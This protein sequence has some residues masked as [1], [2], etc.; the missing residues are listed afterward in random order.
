MFIAA[1]PREEA[2]A[3]SA[4]RAA[5]GVL[6][7]V[8]NL[9]VPFDRRVWQEAA[10]LRDAG[11]RVSV[12]CPTGRGHE[13][14]H[15]VL[16]DIEIWRH[17]VP[18]ARGAAG[19]LLEYLWALGAQLRLSFRAAR[20]R[21]FDVIHA[22]NP[23]DLIFLVAAVHKALRGTRFVF[24]HHDLSPELF[25]SKFG[26]RGA[27]HRLLRW[28]ERRTF[29]LADATIAT[30]E[31]FKR[32]A[33]ERGGMDPEKVHV[34]KSYPRIERFVR[35]DPDPDL[36]ASGR[37]LVGYVG[38]MGGQ[39]G[40]DRLVRAMAVIAHE[41]GREDVGCVIVGD[42]PELPS[43]RALARELGVADRIVFTGYLGGEKLLAALSALDVG[44]IPDPPDGF[45]E[46]LSMNKVF[47]YMM[48]GLPFVMFDLA[49]AR[50]E[51]REAALVVGD[52]RAEALAD[53]ILA[54][55]DD[56]ERR[57]RMGAFG[58]ETAEREFLWSR[59]SETLVRAYKSLA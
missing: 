25:E 42:G 31:T 51:A 14:R 9:P 39:D 5:G 48:L 35:T 38:I 41:R 4:E 49:Q 13:S 23:P 52:D 21:G 17:S 20:S 19:Y 10:A 1:H 37:S 36:T 44:V 47:E 2:A 27:M 56:P 15:E 28:L 16:E 12:I 34:V 7:I 11:W 40:V 6:I 8:E 33:V 57:A 24:D 55:L 32:I 43:L 29:A 18:E 50:S 59:E 45:N 58:R 26:R 22:C 30:N 54:L 46:K 53:G 3:A